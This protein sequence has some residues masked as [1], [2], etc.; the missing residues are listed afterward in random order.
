M[1]KVNEMIPSKFL[2]KED[3][4]IGVLVTIGNITKENVAQEGADPE[5]KYCM[6]FAELDKPLVLNST[7]L[8]ILQAILLSDESDDWTGKKIVLYTDPTVSFGGKVVG[9][10]RI[11]QPKDT[12]A[13]QALPF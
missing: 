10:I 13:L 9:G 1:P 5:Y 4:G 2:K 3:V 8:H 6:S 11:R 12:A 7:N